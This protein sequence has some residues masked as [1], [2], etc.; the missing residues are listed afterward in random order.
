MWAAWGGNYHTVRVFLDMGADV[1][2]KDKDGNTPLMW[3]ASFGSVGGDLD[4]VE[5]FL[6]QGAEVNAKNKKGETPLTW[7]A[8]QGNEE[9]ARL[10]RQH[11]AKE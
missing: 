6:D 1:N 7:A 4:V 3:V 5:M 10:L 11:G 9:V 2:T 8:R